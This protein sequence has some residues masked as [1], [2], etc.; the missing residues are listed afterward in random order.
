[1]RTEL[2]KIGR[3]ERH[4]YQALYGGVG[5][6]RN[7]GDHFLP[8][9]LLK[10][11]KFQETVVADHLWVNYTRGFSKLGKLKDGDVIIFDG[12]VTSYTKGYYTQAKQ[13][14]YGLERPTKIHL[15][16]ER[17]TEPIP[18]AITNKNPL[19]GYIMKTNKEF[20]LANNRP[21]D[22]WY[23]TQYEKWLKNHI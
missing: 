16:E 22:S 21:Y 3:K 5:F 6:K 18:D 15:L 4:T 19:V 10:D 20:Y 14:E 13:K 2:K 11:V 9:L 12:R 7:Y 23:V 8:T 1:M 17:E